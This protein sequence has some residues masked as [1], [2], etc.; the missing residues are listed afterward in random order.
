M[1]HDALTHLIGREPHCVEDMGGSHW[2][3]AKC[4]AVSSMMGHGDVKFCD[5]AREQ[6]RSRPEF[7]IATQAKA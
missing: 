2:H 3:C 7:V 5:M 1:D 4:G 6:G